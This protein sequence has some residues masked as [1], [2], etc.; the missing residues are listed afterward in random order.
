MTEPGCQTDSFG[1]DTT[2]KRKSMRRIKMMRDSIFKRRTRV[3]EVVVKGPSSREMSR[4]LNASASSSSANG[5]SSSSN[6]GGGAFSA[7]GGSISAEDE[8]GRHPGLDGEPGT[9]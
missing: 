8:R 5:N 7:N 2:M 4:L 3:D 9:L 6:G 1:D